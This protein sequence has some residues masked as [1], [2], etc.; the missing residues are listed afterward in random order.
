VSVPGPR[1][2]LGPAARL[3]GVDG[4]RAA[5]ALWVVLFH[6]HAFS[7][8]RV[9]VPGVDLF[10]RSGSIGVSLFLVLSGFCLYRPFAGGRTARFSARAFFVRRGRRL[11]PAYLTSL[12]CVLAVG[13]SVGD[14]FGLERLDA[15]QALWQ[16]V[17]HL[18]LT[19]SLF[20]STFY[21]LNGAYWSLGLEWQ[22]YLGLPLLI[23]GTRRFGL[24]RT[25]AVVVGVNVADRLLLATAIAHHVVPS[26]SLL[27]S[28]V[29]PNQLPG[30][31]AEFA[32]GMV[33]AELH[34]TGRVGAWRRPARVAA[35]ALVP[36]S[37]AAVGTAL[38]HLLFGAVFL[39]LL[40]EVLAG[41]SVVSRVFSWRPLVA[42]GTMSYSLYL[43]HQPIV[44]GLAHVLRS[45]GASPRTTFALLLLAL[46][47]I[48]LVARLL[49][50][51]VERRTLSAETRPRTE[52]AVPAPVAA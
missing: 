25:V 11:L 31:W 42:V 47:P 27:A 7:G 21:A 50:V 30:R 36:I 15:G 17:T 51:T 26:A 16:A 39:A 33:A 12:V 2:P 46:A 10:L 37:I 35:V 29:L 9:P 32:F 4:L 14:R 1:V 49:F 38:S 22:L 28:A 52:T 18:T 8:A 19:H 20:P 41:D 48:L 40:V 23:L 34:V 44:Q 45:A 24:V 13:L 3:S 6:M 5:A 43:V